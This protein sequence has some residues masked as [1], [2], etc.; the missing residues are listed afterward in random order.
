MLPECAQYFSIEN[1]FV[2]LKSRKLR[3]DGMTNVEEMTGISK[4]TL[5]WAKRKLKTKVMQE[6]ASNKMK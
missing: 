2:L 4:S 1:V 3:C 5:I 6:V